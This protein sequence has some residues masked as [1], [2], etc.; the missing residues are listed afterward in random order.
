[1]FGKRCL[2][3]CN[4]L[5]AVQAPIIFKIRIL[6]VRGICFQTLLFGLLVVF[7]SGSL[8][9]QRLDLK[10]L[11]KYKRIELPFVIENDFMVISIL[12]DNVLPLRFI[13]DTGA[14]NT[15]LLEKEITD[16][17]GVTYRRTFQIRGADVENSLT[18][19]LATGIDLRIANRPT[20]PQ[21]LHVGAGR[22]LLRLRTNYRYV[23]PGNSWGGLLNAVYGGV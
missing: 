7:C 16:M 23:H 19:Y 9:G 3:N 4:Y 22:K 5:S 17:L 1:M 18:A 20:C 12:L 14:E 8:L 13:I 21:P 11:G 10:I 2:W 6:I 15:I